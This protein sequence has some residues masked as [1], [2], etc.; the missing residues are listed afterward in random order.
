[1]LDKEKTLDAVSIAI[2]D[3]QHAPAAMLAMAA[4]RHVYCEK[5][6]THSVW[7]ARQLTLAARKY[8]VIT[9]MGNQGHSGE[10]NRQLCEM[11]AAGA[12]G[13]VREVHCWTDR[14]VHVEGGPGWVQGHERPPGSDPVPA[15]LDWDL[16]LG[17]APSRPFLAGWPEDKRVSG[18]LP[19]C[20]ARLV[21]FWLRRHRRHG[22]PYHGRPV[23]GVEA[24][25]SLHGGTGQ[26]HQA[27]AGNGAVGVRH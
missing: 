8:G 14:P 26:V 18:L 20:L 10:G 25:R 21:G 4:G 24:G 17:P 6:L 5:P 11:I 19:S 2:P 1:M 9:Q 3:H 22:L 15:T 23:L 12:I 16:W 13:P 7:E 27:H